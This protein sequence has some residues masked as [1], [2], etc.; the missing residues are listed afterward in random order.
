MNPIRQQIRT[1]T[2]QERESPVTKVTAKLNISVE[3]WVDNVQRDAARIDVLGVEMRR[4]SDI[5]VAKLYGD[6]RDELN[7]LKYDIRRAM[8][9]AGASV[10]FSESE[11]ID[12]KISALI[13]RLE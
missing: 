2:F 8:I 5:V 7:T 3:S 6:I 1:E 10:L 4:L 13:K 11:A 12:A 9:N